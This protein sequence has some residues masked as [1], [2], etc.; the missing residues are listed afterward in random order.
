MVLCSEQVISWLLFN[1]IK[2]KVKNGNKDIIYLSSVTRFSAPWKTICLWAS[3]SRIMLFRGSLPLGGKLKTTPPK[4]CFKAFLTNSCVWKITL[5]L[6]SLLAASS[7]FM[8]TV[9]ICCL[10]TM[11]QQKFVFRWCTADDGWW[12]FISC[13]TFLT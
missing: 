13:Y 5:Q 9:Y 11:L 8:C 4:T 10:Y 1:C 2:C 7:L 6:L 12:I 3:S